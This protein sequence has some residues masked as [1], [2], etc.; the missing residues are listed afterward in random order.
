MVSALTLAACSSENNDNGTDSIK[1]LTFNAVRMQK[2]IIDAGFDADNYSWLT[3]SATG[4]TDSVISNAR[5]F[6]FV[7]QNEGTEKLIL[8]TTKAGIK[9]QSE[10]D[11]HVSKESTAYSRNISGVDE[12]MPAPG[13]Y[14]N[15][16]PE[17]TNGDTQATMNGKAFASLK[18]STIITLGAYGGYVT[19][20]FDHTIA[21]VVGKKDFAIF[22]NSYFA[23]GSSTG[24]NAEPGIVEVAFDKN[25]NGKADDDEWYELAGSNYNNCTHN[26][27]ITYTHDAMK[28]TPWTDSNGATGYVARNTFHSQDYFPQW[29]T[30]DKLTFKGTLLPKNATNK[31]TG[32][33]EYWV[34]DVFDWG[35]VDNYPNSNIEKCSFDISWAV[36]NEG[37][38]IEL[39]GADF[40]RVYSAE[41][42]SCGW[43]G[44]TS[45]EVSGARDLNL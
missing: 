7:G 43:I 26:Y 5:K 25:L 4:N 2:Q 17:Y 38:K 13:Q 29:I 37:N 24:G 36:D 35:Y 39:P 42:Q 31:G 15:T 30:A 10:C 44:E 20:H 27:Q 45:T 6:I 3:K 23:P 11:I 28:D 34:L 12:Y 18:D 16:L 1:T 21:N 14:V 41:N 32:G 40:I 33:T 22:G 8:M 19:F 9:T